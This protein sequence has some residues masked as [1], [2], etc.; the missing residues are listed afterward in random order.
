M[1]IRLNLLAMHV[2]FNADLMRFLRVPFSNPFSL[3]I[4]LFHLEP[5]ICMQLLLARIFP[6]LLRMR[7]ENPKVGY[8][9][10]VAIYGSIA[11]LYGGNTVYLIVFT[12][13][14]ALVLH[15]PPV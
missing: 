12:S 6:K 7:T 3:G 15:R 8:I 5:E 14:W 4:P 13:T 2:P 10:P 1:G 9:I 11:C